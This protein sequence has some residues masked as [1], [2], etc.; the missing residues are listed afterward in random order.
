MLP[1]L[2]KQSLPSRSSSAPPQEGA[3]SV[4][5]RRLRRAFLID[6][7]A[8]VSVFPISSAQKKSL[9][10][11]S[12]NLRA[13]NGS[14]IRTFGKRYIFLA[15][16][17]LSVVH[18]FLLADVSKPILGSDFFRCNNLLIDIPRKRLFKPR[19]GPAAGTVVRARPA[20][21]VQGLYGLRHHVP[22]TVDEVFAE[23]PAVT[24][25]SSVYDSSGPAK[26]GVA[27]TIPTTGRLFLPGHADSSA[28][29]W[30]SPAVC[31][32]RW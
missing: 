5:C 20:D 4:F 12:T 14:S 9:P 2:H 10:A 21:F 28:R 27:H 1:A 24:S 18:R 23:F 25:P 17:G 26:H 31:F 19:E 11:A 22:V 13:A 15:L 6:S 16:P 29:N 3:L 30:M 32:R 8:D 7:G